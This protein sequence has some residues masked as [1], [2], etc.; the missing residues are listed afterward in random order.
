[1]KKTRQKKL[2]VGRRNI[3]AIAPIMKKAGPHQRRD[4]GASRARQKARLRREFSDVE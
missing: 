2:R 1:M 4:K 3:L